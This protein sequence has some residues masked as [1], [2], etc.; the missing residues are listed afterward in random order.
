M[1]RKVEQQGRWL[2]DKLNAQDKKIAA[3]GSRG[4]LAYSSIEDGAIVEKDLDGNL[5]SSV[6]KQHDGS[7]VQVPYVGPIPDAPVAASLKAVPGVVEVRWSGKFTGDAVSAMD[8][9]HVAVHVSTT[10][11]VDATPST[12]VAT[13]R[14]ELGDVATVTAVEGMLY[15]VLVAWSAAGKASD[16]SPVAAV[17]VPGT[18]D[19][20]WINDKLDD[21]DEKYDG[22]ITEAGQLGTR[23]TD[24]EAELVVHEGRLSANDTAMGTL[25]GTTLPNLRTELDA[26]KATL[27]PLPGKVAESEAAIATAQGQVTLLK[28]T[29]VPALSTDLT[30]AKLRLSTAEG[31]LAPLPGKLATAQTDLSTAFVQLGTVDSRVAA[32]KAAALTAAATDATAKANQAKV[33]ATAAAAL[34]A[35]AKADTAKAEALTAAA[36][37]A[38]TKADAAQA[39]AVAAAKTATDLAAAGAKAE[40][41]AAATLD[42][43]AK[44]DAAQAA[45]VTAAATAADSKVATAK[46]ATLTEAATAAQTKADKA[47]ADAKLDASTKAAQA[48]TDA[49]A[50]AKLKADAAQAAAITAAATTAQSKADAAKTDAIFAASITA[51]AKADA[52]KADAI[53]SATA[54][55]A[56][57]AKTKADAAQAAALASAKSYADLQASGASAS[58]IATAAADAKTKADA[59]QAAAISSAAATAQSKADAA[60]AAAISAAAADATTKANAATAVANVA[61]AKADAAQAAAG[62]A[63]A[64]ATAAL[65]MAGSKSKVYYATALPTG[66]AT[67]DGDL[68]RQRDAGNNI[69]GEWRWNGTPPAGAWVKT[70]LSSDAIS[71]LDIGKLSAGA[72]AIDTAVINKLAVQIAT[73]IQLNADRITAGKITSGQV[74]TTNLAAALATILSLNA[75]RITAGTLGAARINVTELAVSI[76]TVIKLNASAITSGTVD[77]ARLNTTTLAA[78]LATILSLNADRITSG[79]INTARL[80]A[81]AIAAATAAF[82]TVDVKN[83]FATTG[84]MSEAVISKLWADVVMSRKITAQMIAVGDFTNLAADGN[85]TDLAKSNWYGSGVV[86][87][88]TSEPNKLKVIVA[89]SGNNDQSN[90]NEFDVSPGEQIYGSVWVYGEA[91]NKGNGTP[92]IH[93]RVKLDNGSYQWPS[94]AIT[95]RTAVSGNWVQLTGMTTVPA[96]ARSAIVEFAVSNSADGVGNVYYFRQVNVRRMNAGELTVDGTVTAR[97]LETQLVLATDIIAGNPLGTHAKMNA[98]GFR[99][100][101]SADGGAPTEVIR[102][103]TDT[104]DYF[105]VANATGELVASI[106]SGGDLSAQSGDFAGEV[107]IAGTALSETL[108]AFP[109]GLVAWGGRG[110][111]A[112]YWAGTTHQP[113]LHLAFDTPPNRMFRISS[114]PIGV[115]SDVATDA[116]VNLHVTGVTT[117]DAQATLATPIVAQG[118]SA[119]GEFTTRRSPVTF[120]RIVNGGGATS[121]ALLISYGTISA[122]RA[123]IATSGELR[124]VYVTVEDIGPSLAQVGEFLD[125]TSDA[126]PS[127][128][129]GGSTT[130]PPATVTKNYTKTY[131]PNGRRSFVGSGATYD[132]NTGYMYSGLSPAGYGDLSSMAVFPSM[133]GDLSGATITSIEVYVYYDFWYQ[134]SGGDAYIG[135]HGQTSL[136]SSRPAKTYAHAVA[137]R[138]PR[139]AGR[140]IKLSSSTYAG[141]KAGTHRGITLGGSGG[142]LER[143]GYAHDPR[144][145]IKYT[146]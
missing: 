23:L 13:I 129:G 124:S 9:K 10:P 53:A 20:G 40:A 14:G 85:F 83:L 137:Q 15:V 7:H 1:T 45:A 138:W 33:D 3:L 95:T 62:A 139:A 5:V 76:A 145:R 135:L 119:Q 136:T 60:K 92:N 143:Y 75:D 49:K 132:Y 108:D 26:A 100:L 141:F 67:G 4:D 58:A 120:N 112:R 41:I 48:L 59:A 96:N 128:T 114:T 79:T 133:T 63:G 122:G 61:Q 80:N 19:P 126:A 54:T 134:G 88:G 102:M 89:A 115:N 125:G 131:F 27:D 52:A 18:V 68:W 65:T 64:N 32:A 12:Q 93:L 42:A 87:A 101:A 57:D 98:N 55:A 11:V 140:W 110:T 22:V 66:V 71:N 31:T 109:K 82:Q 90:R 146:K 81:E 77:T 84:T 43:K 94:F 117:G 46:A 144:I 111:D 113:Y 56:A 70:M 34:V 97:Q 25:T 16:P 29:T 24:A 86:V 28:D 127:G 107:S 121:V 17:V 44:A 106:T 50:D 123:K 72:A 99:V 78:S 38:K 73:V 105:G 47:L 116:V 35:Q 39:A 130:P 30:A 37:D 104:D 2:A 8:F 118:I 103:G 21:L 6:G 142:G 69:I 91:T 36:T 74:D 51:Q